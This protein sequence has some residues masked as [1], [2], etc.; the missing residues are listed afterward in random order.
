MMM[1]MM[2]MMIK[3]DN[4]TNDQIA[5]FRFVN[6]IKSQPVPNPMIGARRVKVKAIEFTDFSDA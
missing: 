4:G 5:N 2:M 1:M 6:N 3:S